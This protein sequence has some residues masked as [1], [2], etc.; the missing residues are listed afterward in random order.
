MSEDTAR[1][2]LAERRAA[3]A[4]ARA[5]RAEAAMR[6]AEAMVDEFRARMIIA[7]ADAEIAQVATA[8]LRQA[9]AARRA[10]PLWARLWAAWRAE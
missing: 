1:A 9:E 6:A 10:R 4:E 8:T 3:E 7:E 2:E 5:D